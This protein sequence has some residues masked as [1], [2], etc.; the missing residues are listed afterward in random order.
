MT[1]SNGPQIKVTLRSIQILDAKD[2]DGEGEFRFH[3]R[4]TTGGQSRELS[5]PDNF[6]RISGDFPNNTVEKID[7]ELYRGPA[8]EK[9][10]VELRGEE[11]DVGK[12]NDELQPYRREFTGDPSSWVGRQHPLDEGVGDAENLEDWRVTYDIE[13]L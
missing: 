1:E 5:F 10:V 4:I 9:L 11:I 8:G 12:S 3:S 2:W 13:L 7:K 6:W